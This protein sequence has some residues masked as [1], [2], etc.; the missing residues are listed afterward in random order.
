VYIY[1]CSLLDCEADLV[2][3]AVY[4]SSDV[5]TVGHLD[6]QINDEAA[7]LVGAYHNAFVLSESLSRGKS[8][9]G[10]TE[11]AYAAYI[12]DSEAV[13]YS[14][15]DDL[16]EVILRD[17]YLADMI[18]KAYH[19]SSLLQ[20]MYCADLSVY[21]GFALLNTVQGN[22]C[23]PAIIADISIITQTNMIYNTCIK[24][25]MRNSP[26]RGK[27]FYLY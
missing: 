22:E 21:K 16:G 14:V 2:G 3:Y 27:I 25:K 12:G 18:F 8:G 23:L 9:Y 10:R 15:F 19:S 1:A 5:G 11:G 6:M 17:S 26:L 20:K 13:R 4:G 24:E 7:F